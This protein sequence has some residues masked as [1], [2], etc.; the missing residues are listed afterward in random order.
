MIGQEQISVAVADCKDCLLLGT[1]KTGSLV[2]KIGHMRV[3][4]GI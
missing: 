3:G 4:Q 2:I 1:D